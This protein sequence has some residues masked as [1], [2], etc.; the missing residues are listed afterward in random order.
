MKTIDPVTTELIKGALTYAC[1]E[2]GVA[3]RNSAYSPNIR[4]RMDHSCSIFDSKK[5]LVAQAEHIPVHLGSMP[6]AVQK[7]LEVYQGSLEPGDMILVNDPAIAGTHLP[8]LTLVKA[9]F[10][11]N[12]IVGYA[13]NKAHHSDIGGK[14]PGSMPSDSKELREEGL[15]IPPIKLLESGEMV[16]DVLDWIKINVRTPKIT[17]GDLKA[18]VAAN[19]TGE[20]RVIE[21]VEKY[22]L[23]LFEDAVEKVMSLSEIRLRKRLREMPEG[24]FEAE[25]ELEDTGTSREPV[26]IMVKIT[27][28]GDSIDI[29]YAGTDKQVEGPVNAPFG[30]TVAGVYYTVKCVTD[31][32][33]PTNDGFSRPIRIRAPRGTILNPVFPAPVAAGNVETSQRNVD[34]LLRAFARMIP[35][36]ICAAGQGTMN[37]VT[38]GGE[39]PTSGRWSF[40]ETIGGGMGGAP[41][42]DGADG[43]QVHMT[44]TMNTPIETIET[45]YPIRLMKY[46]FRTDSGGPGKWRGGAGIERTWELLADEAS[47]SILAERNRIPP[48]GLDGGKP[49][50][51]GEYLLRSANGIEK[52]LNSKT[53]FQMKKGEQLI[54][55]TP[56]GGGHGDPFERDPQL[57]LRDVL[58][59]LVS[60][61]GAEQEYAVKI[62]QLTKEI[63]WDLTRKL[64]MP[65]NSGLQPDIS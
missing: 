20:R 52:R 15:I 43:V 49:G 11:G 33:I 34:A 12:R 8:D 45:S 19:N 1:E 37:N 24:E 54:I 32:T 36:R 41:G 22:G 42:V 25:D 44:N 65:K 14:T 10:F 50:R 47:V 61:E 13:A 55:R 5:R 40:Y 56:G 63:L 27:K 3:L 17:I 35:E 51:L 60:V 4:E 7:T 53:S 58:D 16:D 6:L 26:R 48:W 21:V 64:R 28:D 30:V 29:D 9:V 2:M 38:V 39:E 46:E 31:P 57:V 18:Q 23:E 59:G 62:D